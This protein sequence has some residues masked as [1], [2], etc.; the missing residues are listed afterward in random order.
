MFLNS[1]FCGRGGDEFLAKNPQKLN[2]TFAKPPNFLTFFLYA[3]TVL[4][5]RPTTS[6]TL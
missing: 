2:W 1:T 6:P 4:T 5:T 3:G